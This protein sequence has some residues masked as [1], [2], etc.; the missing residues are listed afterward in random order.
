MPRLALVGVQ[1]TAPAK[2][3]D[4]FINGSE[5]LDEYKWLDVQISLFISSY[6]A[7]CERDEYKR[8]GVYEEK[9][10]KF[11]MHPQIKSHLKEMNAVTDPLKRDPN[12]KSPITYV[13]HITPHRFE[14]WLE[15]DL[16]DT[17]EYSG[18]NPYRFRDYLKYIRV[19]EIPSEGYVST[20]LVCLNGFDA[21]FYSGKYTVDDPESREEAIYDQLN[22]LYFDLE[23][24]IEFHERELKR[25]SNGE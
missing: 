3:E 1:Q 11:K 13:Y 6:P 15:P 2:K 4:P 8:M 23:R 25:K 22:D 18:Y 9:G 14:E 16:E 24:C 21:F 10:D 5:T 17:A 19:R 12:D 7:Y 20:H